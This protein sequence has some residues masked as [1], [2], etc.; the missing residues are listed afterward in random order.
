MRFI[1][2][3]LKLFKEGCSCIRKEIEIKDDNE[4]RD[5]SSFIEI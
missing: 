1:Y 2:E 5:E 3:K 4:I